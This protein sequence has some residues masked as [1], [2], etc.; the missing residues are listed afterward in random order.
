MLNDEFYLLMVIVSS[1]SAFLVLFGIRRYHYIINPLFIFA[2]FDIGL[3]TLVSAVVVNSLSEGA[4]LGL[5]AVL[6]LAVVYL[7]GFFLIFLPRRFYFPRLLFEGLLTMVGKKSGT[8]GYGGVS[9]WLL[10]MVALSLFF[11]LMKSS[12][13]GV[14]W[15][16]DPGLA[17][18][19]Y[20][21][22]SGFIYVMVQW[23]L[24]ASLIYYV[25]NRKPRLA[26]FLG[27]V[28]L[29]SLAAYFT[30]SKANVLAGFVM[31]G[32]Y[33]YFFIKK[34]PTMLILLAP[35]VGLGS[36]LILL[37]LQGS[38]NDVF[39]AML[40]FRDYAQTTGQFLMRFNEFGYHWGYG[41]LSDLWFYVPRALYA[42]KPYEYGIVLI[43]KV[44]FSG[45][46]AQGHTP[47]VL[48]WALAYL[49]F[50]VV[51]VFFSGMIN[52]VIRRGA[53]ESF[54]SNRGSVLAF[55]LM[56]QLSLLP[57]FAYATLPLIIIIGVLLA[58]FMRNKIVFISS[59]R[60]LN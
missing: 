8:E 50:G 54:L 5:T 59:A 10:I 46:A 21:A 31:A 12:G 37:I 53:Y 1:L 14:L 55:V 13:A 7:V 3:L 2:L 27:V 26:G 24:L 28:C 57:V 58:L 22:G 25:W 34:I 44:L 60:R 42:D 6:S 33:Y 41:L 45:A 40:Y 51:G 17:Y 38:Y 30:G 49:D 15:L 47:G 36:F 11:L 20:R 56:I 35:F 4:D 19:S 32:V 16:T 48:P 52:G 23:A 18:L 39:S 9:Q 29:Y 43:H